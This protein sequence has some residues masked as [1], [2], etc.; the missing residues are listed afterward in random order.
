MCIRDSV[1]TESNNDYLSTTITLSSM[2]E[3]ARI[4]PT[5]TP[6]TIKNQDVKNLPKRIETFLTYN[7]V[8]LIV[9]PVSIT[10]EVCNVNFQYIN[11]VGGGKCILTYQTNATTNYLAS[12]VYQSIFEVVKD[13]QT[14]SFFPQPSESL[15]KENIEL[16][17]TAS[18][19]GL[20]T[21][22][23]QT[24]DIC[25]VE[26]T[27]LRLLKAGECKVSAI[28]A[29]TSMISQ[30]STNATIQVIGNSIQKTR[31][32]ICVKGKSSRKVT[33]EKPKCPKGFS[34]NKR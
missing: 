31:S 10:P 19:G 7:S 25:R 3:S 23:S 4:K 15:T 11:I 8:G 29:G 21:F 1:Y 5:I 22:Q 27:K 18:S 20:V 6:P 33:G 9:S 32:I 24:L 2:I 13:S 12:D 16:V 26:V 34:L 17:A 14:I 28:Q 30:V